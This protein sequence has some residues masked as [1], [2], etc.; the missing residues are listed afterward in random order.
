MGIGKTDLGRHIWKQYKQYKKEDGATRQEIRDDKKAVKS[1][2]M[3]TEEVK[4]YVNAKDVEAFLKYNDKAM[5]GA[6]GVQFSNKKD[7]NIDAKTQAYIDKTPA[8]VKARIAETTLANLDS[9]D[10]QMSGAEVQTPT[11]DFMAYAMANIKG[12]DPDKLNRHLEKGV[13]EETAIG[14]TEF[15]DMAVA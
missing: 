3:T 7:L 2:E 13:S 5:L 11:G 12:A 8:E 1:G 14:V 9:I 15:L 4:A 6:L 10:K